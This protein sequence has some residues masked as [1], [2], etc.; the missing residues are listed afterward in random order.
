MLEERE[1]KIENDGFVET[2]FT[3]YTPYLR[4]CVFEIFLNKMFLKIKQNG[5]KQPEVVRLQCKLFKK[6][7]TVSNW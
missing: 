4:L 3:Y 7:I 6:I 5:K 2:K 1:K